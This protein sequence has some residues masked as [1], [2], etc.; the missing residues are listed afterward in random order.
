V[1]AQALARHRLPVR[2]EPQC[3]VSS[4]IELDARDVWEF[5]CR[6]YTIGKLYAP[7]WWWGAV[8]YVGL[9]QGVFWSSLAAAVAG[10][11]SGG[12]WRLPAAVALA[13]Y[14]I[15]CGR[16]W[17]RQSASKSFLPE[18]Q[19]GLEAARRCDIWLSPLA[20]LV[21]A[22]CL[23]AALCRRRI[24]WRG[25]GYTM[26][27]NGRVLEVVRARPEVV[28][29]VRRGESQPGVRRAG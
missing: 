13:L 20:G 12:P 19:P 4:R 26:S 27:R 16:S 7:G 11:A 3:M 14:L 10:L 17:L 8:A 2:F 1:A 24:V 29:R 18:A 6:Q 15:S 5:I 28:P 22:G 25:I 21:N 9:T 23:A